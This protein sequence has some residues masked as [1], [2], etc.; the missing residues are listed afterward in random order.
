MVLLSCFLSAAM[1]HK[2]GSLAKK[3]SLLTRG[4]LMPCL[5]IGFQHETKLMHDKY[6]GRPCLAARTQQGGTTP[7]RLP[8]GERACGSSRTSAFRVVALHLEAPTTWSR[9]AMHYSP[10]L[11]WTLAAASAAI[12]SSLSLIKSMPFASRPM[13]AKMITARNAPSENSARA[14]P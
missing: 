9:A 11:G 1:A 3:A 7:L 13:A 8:N 4:S 5:R 14:R 10:E 12:S 2:A 6:P